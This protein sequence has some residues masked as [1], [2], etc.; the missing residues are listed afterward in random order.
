MKA[1]L[2]ISFADIAATL[3]VILLLVVHTSRTSHKESPAERGIVWFSLF[4]H[5]VAAIAMI[6]LTVMY[7]GGG[8]MFAYVRAGRG[9]ARLLRED[10]IGVAPDVIAGFF[11]EDVYLPVTALQFGS[12]TGST[13]AIAGFLMFLTF[14]SVYGACAVI[15][16]ATFLAKLTILRV[17]R[18]Y[19]PEM[20][21]VPLAVGCMLLP[22]VVFWSSG[23]LK[24]PIGLVGIAA[25]V[26]G[27]HALVKK[28][29]M[30]ALVGILAGS[31]LVLLIKGYL[32]PPLGIAGFSWLAVH[33]LARGDRNAPVRPGVIVIAVAVAILAVV[34]TGS[35]MPRFAVDSFEE[36][37]REAQAVGA[38]TEGGSNYSLPGGSVFTQLPFALVAVL[39]RPFLFE[40]TNPII[41]MSALEM[42]WL[43]ILLVLA[44][45][46]RGISGTISEVL[47]NPVV[48][49]SV[50]F[51]LTLGVGIGLA[52]TNLGSLSRYRMPLM[53]FYFVA[54]R[55]LAGERRRLPALQPFPVPAAPLPVRSVPRSV[56]RV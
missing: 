19:V 9:I 21:P 7:F 34:V 40:A 29:S 36:E 11:R 20:S 51:T 52:T 22:S 17:V 2:Q 15:A 41:A 28:R 39:F 26:G 8:D 54:L 32:L 55:V 45:R 35:V 43:S 24:E 5:Q 50:A 16:G 6:W 49:F 31:T 46:R 53:P 25:I 33:A 56:R 38:R 4:A 14:D 18:E 12:T 13:K 3:L 47:R 44:L 1:A 27:V 23:L 48:A 30:L 42:A 10:F 37:V